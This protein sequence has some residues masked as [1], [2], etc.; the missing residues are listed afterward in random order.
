MNFFVIFDNNLLNF[1]RN[2]I[3]IEQQFSHTQV[4]IKNTTIAVAVIHVNTRS[5][6]LYINLNYLL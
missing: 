3:S 6:E 4:D 5:W 2:Q 1:Y